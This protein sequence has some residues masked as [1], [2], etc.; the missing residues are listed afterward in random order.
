MPRLKFV[1]RYTPPANIEELRA[2]AD[3]V[4]ERDGITRKEALRMGNAKLL[5]RA[6][7]IRAEQG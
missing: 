3:L 6:G 1:A 2:A 4:A 5:E 7:Q